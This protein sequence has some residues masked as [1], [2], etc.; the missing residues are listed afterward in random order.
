[1]SKIANLSRK[2]FALAACFAVTAGAV[3]TYV[4]RADDKMSDMK[5]SDTKVSSDE[6]KMAMDQLDKMKKDASDESD[7]MKMNM[8]KM[9]V[10]E[11]MS[12]GLSKDADFQKASMDLMDDSTFKK[13]P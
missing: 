5:M 13:A 12:M 4:V 8:A 11:H 7:K 9:M 2:P 6:S 10:M 3:C 1:M